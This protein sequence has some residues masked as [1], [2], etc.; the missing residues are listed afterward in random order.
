VTT[1][2]KRLF[3]IGNKEVFEFYLAAN[4]LQD[5]ASMNEKREYAAAAYEPNQ[6]KIFVMGGYPS[7]DSCEYYDVNNNEW[8]PFAKLSEKKRFMS[9]SILNS[10]FIYLFGGYGDS[11]LDTIEQYDITER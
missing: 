6:D 3:I 5:R 10:R 1:K 11:H 9:A 2:D 8:T 4:T 7:T